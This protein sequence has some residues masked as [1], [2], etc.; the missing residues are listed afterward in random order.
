MPVTSRRT[1]RFV[2]L[3]LRLREPLERLPVLLEPPPV[4]LEPLRLPERL[5][6][7]VPPLRDVLPRL[8]DVVF[9]C[10]VAMNPPLP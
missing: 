3:V 2:F 6:A 8:P 5:L 9:F 4:L 1:G 10:V 7:P